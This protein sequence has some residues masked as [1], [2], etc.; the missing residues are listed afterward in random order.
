[1]AQPVRAWESTGNQYS[2]L[3]YHVNVKS[4]KSMRH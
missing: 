1:V 3:D 2:V 4:R